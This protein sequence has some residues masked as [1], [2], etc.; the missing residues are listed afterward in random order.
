[1]GFSSGRNYWELTIVEM[2]ADLGIYIGICKKTEAV[3]LAELKDTYGL[4]L[5]EHKKFYRVPDAGNY[6]LDKKLNSKPA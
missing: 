3:T 6:K 5:A 4:L 1:M 2:T